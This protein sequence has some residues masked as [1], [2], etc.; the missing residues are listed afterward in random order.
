[1]TS[2]SR[3][4]FAFS[5]DRA[6]PGS[7]Y[8]SKLTASR[9]PANAVLMVGILSALVTLPSLIEV[10]IGTADAP[11]IVPVAFYAVTSIAVIGLYVAFAIPIWL[12]WRHGDKFEVGAWNNGNKYKW[13]NL[14][15][16]AEIV[17]VSLYLMLPFVPGAVPFSDDFAWKYVNYAPIVT[18]GAVV[19]ITIWWEVSAKNWFKGPLHTID[20]TVVEVFDDK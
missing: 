4:T 5:R 18:I 9:V 19:A 11:L 1:M 14:I 6:I 17:I 2:A 3:M 13:M 8:L 12:R 10:N 16:V 15:A 7:R 20:P